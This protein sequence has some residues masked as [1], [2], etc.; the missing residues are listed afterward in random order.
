MQTYTAP[1]V[2]PWNLLFALHNSPCSVLVTD[3]QGRVEYVNEMF[4]QNSG[5]SLSEIIG[6]T[7][8]RVM[9][10][11]QTDPLVY[12]EM[13]ATL[14]DGR[15][16]HGDLI[17][18]HKRGK[19]LHERATIIPVIEDGVTN[20][21]ISIQHGIGQ[22]VADHYK[23]SCY[24][25]LFSHTQ[26]GIIITDYGNRI[27]TV[28]PALT[29][30]TGYSE[31]EVIGKSPGMLKAGMMK[32]AFYQTMWQ[33]LNLTDRWS[34]ELLNR[35]KNGETYTEWLC[36]NVIRDDNGDPL[37]H[38]ATITDISE[39]KNEEQRLY[40][41]L[42]HD[43]LTGLHN[44]AKL[45]E[46]VP[47]E[48][49]RAG[50]NGSRFALM[51]LDLD[52]FKFIN[53]TRGHETGDRV[54][55]EAALRISG[56]IRSSDF[57]CRHGGDEFV[58]LLTDLSSPK[59]VAEVAEKLIKSLDK[60]YQIDSMELNTSCSIGIV[61][62]PDDATDASEL[63]RKADMAMYKAKSRG[64]N[65]YHFFTQ[66]IN[67][68]ILHRQSIE[69]QLRRALE[70]GEFSMH[71]QPVIDLTSGQICSA[72]AL[73]RWRQ[74]EKSI[75]PADFIPIAEETG[76]ILPIGDWVLDE[77]GRQCR[78]WLDQ[79]KNVPRIAVNLS[80]AQFH[81]TA[82]FNNIDNV[83]H[84]HNLSAG[85]FEVEITESAAIGDPHAASK[86]LH[87]L[88][89]MGLHVALDDFG[90][91][92]SSL[93]YLQLF[94]LDKLKIDRTFVQHISTNSRDAAIT[95]AIIDL[96]CALSLKLVAEGIEYLE[97]RDLLHGWGC[98]LGQGYHFN[99]PLAHAEF[100]KLL[101]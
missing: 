78:S 6:Q 57:V 37:Y 17:N 12:E 81:E 44:R 38:V 89:E 27:L 24:E 40:R 70:S 32:P 2:N 52:R 35:R 55:Q 91:G 63:I 34:G 77:V 21:F 22:T 90:T 20:N 46:R 61:L 65:R 42:H 87:T 28:N 5:F 51:F 1:S 86:I 94:P 72:E 60:T 96:A 93:T 75:S 11:G 31:A 13:W 9:S 45:Q 15:V 92:Y 62:F 68:T 43:F 74:G 3:G 47:E 64:G 83:L 88:R 16:W 95:R 7:P 76:L 85:Q 82:L 39:R 58:L 100:A 54:L 97:Q 84:R 59:S 80:T 14:K 99:K 48:I 66:D 30:I 26:I 67:D 33:T 8:G 25:A 10:S 41:L 29:D 49:A 23:L 101:R 69:S 4:V 79:G 18:R 56:Q 19:I 53:D 98:H 71:Y 73:I 50:R 36:I